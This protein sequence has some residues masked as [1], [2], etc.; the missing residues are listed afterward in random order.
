MCKSVRATMSRTS[1]MRIPIDWL[2]EAVISGSGMRPLAISV[3]LFVRVRVGARLFPRKSALILQEHL[4]VLQN[5]PLIG[6]M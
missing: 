5:P 2:L 1:R 3:S 4:L 6:F